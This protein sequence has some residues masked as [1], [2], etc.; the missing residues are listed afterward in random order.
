MKYPPEP[1][2]SLRRRLA[3]V[4]VAAVAIT[5]S[6]CSFGCIEDIAPTSDDAGTDTSIEADDP[7][8]TV[9]VF[10]EHN[11]AI[12]DATSEEDWIHVDLASGRQVFVVDEA[13]DVRWDVAF[14]RFNVVLNG[15][16]SGDAGV[17][18]TWIDD[19]RLAE[20]TTSPSEGWRT[21]A[22]DGDDEDT[23]PDLA[24]GGWWDYDPATHVLTPFSRVYVIR[25]PDG[26]FAL[27]MLDYYN[28]AGSSGYPSFAW[29]AVGS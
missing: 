14:R 20:V 7:N 29:K 17:E 22:P 25:T 27:E 11:E 13:A 6:V 16:V 12:V 8:V 28:A 19:V 3:T 24:L 10:D 26:D 18:A 4:P 5:L 23:E 21:D 2:L 1:Y 9:F 15:G